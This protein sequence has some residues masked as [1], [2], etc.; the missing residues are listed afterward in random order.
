MQRHSI[1]VLG[2]GLTGLSFAYHF[3]KSIPIY[4]KNCYVGGLAHTDTINRYKFDSAP[5]LL[6]LRSDEAKKLLFDDLGLKVAKHIRKAA[7]YIDKRIIPYPFELN[8]YYLSDKMK[9]ECIRGLKKIDSSRSINAKNNISKWESYKDYA[10][11]SFGEGI[12]NI[13]LLPYNR[14]VWDTDPEKLTYEWMHLLPTVE[15]DE[16]IKNSRTPI[17]F[18]F[19]YNVDFYYPLSYGIQELPDAFSKRLTNIYLNEEVLRIDINEKCIQFKNGNRVAYDILVSTLPLKKIINLIDLND[20]KK[21]ADGLQSTCVYNINIVI[22][23]KIPEGIHW[24]YFPENEFEFY[25]MSFPKNYFPKCTPN[26]EQIIAV[27]IGSRDQNLNFGDMSRRV[28]EKILKM[29]IFSLQEIISIHQIKIPF[30]YCIYDK[31]RTERV[32]FLLKQLEKSGVL[33]TGRYGRWEYSSMEDA[34]LHG[35]NLALFLKTC[36]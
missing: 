3:D 10:T 18:R 31:Q 11:N 22:K 15:V 26:N 25:R 4:E 8:L 36:R 32:K 7:I 34:I 6:H 30:A 20:F 9:N 19:G 27:E 21:I 35:K 2:A 29:D 13:Y 23:G 14:K 16:I 28:E 1:V 5:H 17:D 24:L 12:A 33:S